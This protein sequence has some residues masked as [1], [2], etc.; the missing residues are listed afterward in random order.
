MDDLAALLEHPHDVH[1]GFS[2]DNH[3]SSTSTKHDCISMYKHYDGQYARK[4]G[5]H[6]SGI[7]VIYQLQLVSS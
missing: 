1:V 7:L 5:T 2:V 6:G 4:F 3:L